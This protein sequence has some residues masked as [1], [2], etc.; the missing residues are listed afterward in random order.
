MLEGNIKSLSDSSDVMSSYTRDDEF[1]LVVNNISARKADTTWLNQMR[2]ISDVACNP[3]YKF[4]Q[5]NFVQCL[6][7]AFFRDL[8]VCFF[9]TDKCQDTVQQPRQCPVCVEELIDLIFRF[10]V[11]SLLFN[12]A[13]WTQRDGVLQWSSSKFAEGMV[14]KHTSADGTICFIAFLK[15]Q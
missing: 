1:S 8:F 12:S 3:S 2:F 15:C 6:G 11:S 13:C 4:F 14:T 5:R 9:C 10:M 7:F